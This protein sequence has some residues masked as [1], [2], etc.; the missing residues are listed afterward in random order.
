MAPGATPSVWDGGRERGYAATAGTTVPVRA[1]LRRFHGSVEL[2]ATRLNRDTATVVDAVGQH[3]VA[4]VNAS[5]R[6]T[7][8][9]EADLPDGAP[10]Q[11]VRTVNEN[12]RTLKFTAFGFEET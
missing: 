6:V 9:I 4:L 11:V 5:V 7:L 1:K 10:E 8:E 12:A 3:L 2:D